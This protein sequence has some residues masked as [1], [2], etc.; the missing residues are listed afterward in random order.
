MHTSTVS[1][2]EQTVE[3]FDELQTLNE[4]HVQKR[5][6]ENNT[7]LADVIWDKTE[8][9]HVMPMDVRQKTHEDA[10]HEQL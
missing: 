4:S 3:P 2:V 5:L 8:L 10:F 6:Q 1:E 9:H 7:G